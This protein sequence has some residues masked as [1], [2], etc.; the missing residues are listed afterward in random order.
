MKFNKNDLR[1]RDPFILVDGGKYY[2]Y[3]TNNMANSAAYGGDGKTPGFSSFVSDDLVTFD[4]PYHAFDRPEGFWGE[5]GYWAPE[6]HKV[7]GAYYMFATFFSK[8]DGRRCQIL[9]SD[10]PLT[11]FTVWSEPI[12]PEGWWC[13]DGTLVRHNGKFYCIFCHEW[14]QVHDG[15][16]WITELAPD[17]RSAVGEPKF[18]FRASEA[19]WKNSRNDSGNYVT[20]GPF[21]HE[22]KNG[23]LVMLWSSFGDGGYTQGMLRHEGDDITTGWS[24]IEK[25][26][27]A[28]DGGHGMVFEKDGKPYLTLHAPNSGS[29]HAHFIELRETADALELAEEEK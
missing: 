21:V 12:T 2:M 29:E 11:G 4:G 22:N 10:N 24:Q 9:R 20:D 14:L 27:Y 19:P 28:G 8:K 25:P 16:M 26:L 18:L 13:L 7:D 23:A 5:E 3:G 6:V 17:L 1:I 15:E